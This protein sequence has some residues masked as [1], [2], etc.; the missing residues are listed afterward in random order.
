MKSSAICID[1]PFF[2]DSPDLDYSETE[3]LSRYEYKTTEYRDG[4]IYPKTDSLVFKTDRR[5]PKVGLLLVG[6]GGN[7]GTTVTAGIL[8]NKLGTTW[9]TKEGLQHPNYHGSLFRATTTRIA[10]DVHGT[11]VYVPLYNMLPMVH[12]NDLVIGGWDISS[13]NLGDAMRRAAVLE[14]DLQDKLY[15]HMAGLHPMPGIYV[16]DFVASNQTARADNVLRGTKQEMLDVLRGNIREF[17]AR[18]EL[19]KVI[20]LW[21]A[22]TERYS[23]VETGYHDTADNLLNAIVADIDEVSPSTIYAVASILEGASYING[24]PQNTFVPGLIELADRHNV[25]I[26]GDDFKSGQTKIKSVLADFL[27]GAGL[28]IKSIVSYNHLGNNDGMNLSAPKT[29]RSKE[30]S[31]ASVVDDIVSSNRI[32]YGPEEHPDHC[33]VIKYVP[34]VGDSKRAMDEYISEIFLN[35]RNTIVMHNTC[36]DSLL[37]API[38][39]DLVILTEL[40]HRISVRKE[41]DDHF[42]SFHTILS[43]CS[44]LLKAPQVPPG[45]PVINALF[46]QKMAIVNVFRACLSLPAENF[47]GLEHKVKSLMSSRA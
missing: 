26:T 31:K 24:S 25:S 10:N 40:C 27:V 37:A 30:I 3:I 7:N 14:L 46:P 1:E 16:E 12:P 34:Y 13:V 20:V 19:D 44:F 39:I 17:K 18:N 38:I 5:V 32:L 23:A 35:G 15:D 2:V 9:R 28:K 22:N 42:E 43:L 47:M 36:E 21:T 4:R 8:A 41:Q 45:T 33:V 11:P 29:F 6:W